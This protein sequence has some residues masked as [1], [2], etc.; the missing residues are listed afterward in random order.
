VSSRKDRKEALRR[1]REERERQA[2]A[3]RQRKRLAGYGVAGA[4]ALA[5]TV[6]IGVLLA[7]GGSDGAGEPSADVLPEGGDV[8]E[9]KEFEVTAAARLGGCELK[10]VKGS[11]NQTHTQDPNERIR[12]NS[13]PPTTG[14]HYITPA[15]DGAYS[16]APTDEALVHGLEHGRV[17]VWYKPGLPKDARADLRALYEEDT[18]QMFLVPRR[19]MPYDVAASAWNAEPAPNGTGRLLVCDR[20]GQGVFDA[21]RAFR[22]EHRSNGPEPVP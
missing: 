19:N 11:G 22:D 17:I 2:R 9:Q 21:I 12:Y 6:V 16:E 18:Y 4:I 14:K 13:N 3:A 15:E 20:F 8:P 1:A 7:A 10:A 5:T